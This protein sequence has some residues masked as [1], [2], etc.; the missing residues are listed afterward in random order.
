MPYTK[1]RAV[2]PLNAGDLNRA[3]TELAI[4]YLRVNGLRYQTINDVV[5][6]L[7]GAKD[8]FNRRVVAPYEDDCIKENGDVYPEGFTLGKPNKGLVEG[9]RI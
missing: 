1:T 3:F 4:E 5:G 7:V 6:A 2:T 8:E 9:A